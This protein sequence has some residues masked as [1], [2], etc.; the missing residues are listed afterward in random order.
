MSESERN[1]DPTR[2]AASRGPRGP[3][4]ATPDYLERAALFYLERYASSTANLRR[5]LLGKVQRSARA[6]GTDPAAGAEAVEA[7]LA[8]F[9]RSGLLDDRAYAEGR[10][11]SLHRAGHSR[12][13]IRARLAQKGVDTASIEAALARLADEAA[14]PDLAAALR[15]ARK[16]G[17]G[18]Y[19]RERRL[20][21]RERDLAALARK[22]FDLDLAR[23]LVDAE[24]PAALE[25]EAGAQPGPLGRN[26]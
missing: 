12:P 17:L 22:G 16:R 19:R 25:D 15:Y 6:H 23:R 2:R 4:K 13:A 20:E 21:R 18:P 11:V 9:Q 5:V 3:R 7:L 26:G 8:R 1:A 24:D 10:A 14:A